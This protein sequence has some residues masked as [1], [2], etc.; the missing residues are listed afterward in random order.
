ML[1]RLRLQEIQQQLF[2][3]RS[4]DRFG[5][6]LNP[7]D[8]IT[9]VSKTHDLALS[10]LSGDL[11][12]RRE[13]FPPHN[14]GVIPSRFKRIRQITEDAVSFMHNGGGF[15]VHNP[16][17]PDDFASENMS[18]A[19]VPQTNAENRRGGAE[20]KNQV[21]A[22][23]GIK[24]RPRSWRDT[25][26]VRMHLGNLIQSNLVVAFNDEVGSELAKILDQVVGKGIVIVDDQHHM[27]W[28]LSMARNKAIALLTHSWCSDSGTESATTPQ[29]AWAKAIPSFNTMVLS[30]MQE[31]RFPS[32]PK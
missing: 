4:H 8:R 14:K 32:N 12:I 2:P 15:P 21:I 7:L 20:L 25:D 1:Y 13:S 19:L 24:R 23:T 27:A 9:P 26:S 29:P 31:S 17:G 30:A 18:N 3:D 6:E 22:D 16:V 11:Q 10:S 5:V 28:A